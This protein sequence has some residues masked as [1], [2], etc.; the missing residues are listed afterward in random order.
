MGAMKTVDEI[1]RAR[2]ALLVDEYGTAARL[3]DVIGCSPAQVSQWINAS[4][5]SKTGKPRGMRKE[6]ARNIEER[7]SRPVG[8]LDGLDSRPVANDQSAGAGQTLAEDEQ[9]VLAAYRQL[10]RE[11]GARLRVLALIADELAAQKRQGS[12]A[13]AAQPLQR[14]VDRASID[15]ELAARAILDAELSGA[16]RRH[17]DAGPPPTGERRRVKQ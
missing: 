13:A 15:K 2:L 7:C 10:G 17:Y 14:G 6:T 12:V 16:E 8:W 5:D 9:Q 11:G 4:K 3:A 1:R